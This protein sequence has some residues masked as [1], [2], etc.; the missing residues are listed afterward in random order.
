MKRGA[1]IPMSR[2]SGDG[3]EARPNC[4]M[5]SR[6]YQTLSGECLDHDHN[7]CESEECR[8]PCHHDDEKAIEDE[9]P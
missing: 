3:I 6:G 8:C 5:A 1:Q 2:D 9:S 4:R 7:D